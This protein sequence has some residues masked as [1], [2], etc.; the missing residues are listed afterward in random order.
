MTWR[1]KF[2][3]ESDVEIGFVEK[4]DKDTY[5][6][7]IT[8]PDPEWSDFKDYLSQFNRVVLETYDFLDSGDWT[9]E[10]GPMAVKAEPEEHLQ[11]VQDQV[12]FPGVARS[13]LIFE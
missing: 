2:Y 5:R 9:A 13:E 4:P 7:S 10:Y 3:D 12:E 8:H 6:V 1:L 11:G